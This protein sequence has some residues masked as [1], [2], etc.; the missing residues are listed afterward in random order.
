LYI[1]GDVCG[2]IVISDGGGETKMAA[3]EDF[4]QV[5]LKYLKDYL[6]EYDCQHGELTLREIHEGEFVYQWELVSTRGWRVIFSQVT[7]EYIAH[8]VKDYVN[9]DNPW[10]RF[11]TWWLMRWL[12]LRYFIER[13]FKGRQS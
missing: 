4:H 5:F 3:T 1:W 11:R 9:W 12:D 7:L 13:V 8:S 10:W 6:D 2:E